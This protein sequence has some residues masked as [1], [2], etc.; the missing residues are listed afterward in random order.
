MIPVV[1]VPDKPSGDPIA[2]TGWPTRRSDEEPR[3]IGV[4][5]DTPCTRITAISL[6]GSAPTTVNGA[7]RPS[8][9]VTVV[10]G[11]GPAGALGPPGAGGGGLA[12]AAMTWLLVRIS[13]SA[14]RT[15]P[16]PSSE[17]R[18]IS[19]SNMTTL[20][21][22]L[23]ATCSTLPGGMFAAGTLGAAPGISPPPLPATECVP[24]STT[25]AA[26]PPIPADTT[27]IATAPTANTPARER[28]WRIGPGG[29]GIGGSIPGIGPVVPV[30]PGIG[31]APVPPGIRPGPIPPGIGPGP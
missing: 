30:P 19:V 21:T 1:T 31:P 7:V 28:F 24:S 26:A 8:E 25:V 23:A 9:E 13:P 27:A 20:G 15:T 3:D 18:P 12:A 4:S 11:G 10:F 16:E 6:V 5:P 2:T 22:T 17:A 29:G 14:D